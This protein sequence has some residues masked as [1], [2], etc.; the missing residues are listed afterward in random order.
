VTCERAD[1]SCACATAIRTARRRRLRLRE[2]DSELRGLEAAALFLYL[3][4]LQFGLERCGLTGGRRRSLQRG[5][6]ALGNR[7]CGPFV[8]IIELRE[9]LSA[10]H[11]L[12]FVDQHA[13]DAFVILLVTRT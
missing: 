10:A 13:I 8:G 3:G 7:E 11:G 9:Q 1:S 4:R 12:V 5:K 6:I 2:G